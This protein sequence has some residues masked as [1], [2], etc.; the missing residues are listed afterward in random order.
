MSPPV[1]R[2]GPSQ[3]VAP[4]PDGEADVED[5]ATLVPE[6]ASHRAGEG[7]PLLLLHGMSMSWRAWSPVLPFLVG[8]HDVF[9]PTLAGHRGGPSLSADCRPGM[10]GIVDLLCAQMDEA[11]IETA[12]VAGNSLGGWVALELA[13]R[14]R[15]RSVIGFSPAGAWQARRDLVRLVGLFRVGR[16]LLEVPG[17]G[18]LM[19][20]PVLQRAG[21]RRTMC[22]PERIPSEDLSEM[23][24]DMLECEMLTVLFA[25]ETPVNPLE[26]FD[27]ALCPV[28]IAWSGRD[29]VIPYHRYGRPLRA[30][31]PG[32][33]F[34]VLPGVGHVPMWDDPRLVARTILETT[35]AVD[36]A[37]GVE[38][39]KAPRRPRRVARSSSAA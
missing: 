38:P 18:P 26:L 27:V 21:L 2:R 6:P 12:H 8:R 39:V 19:R 7:T 23:L 28:H 24:A 29:K 30:L 4:V 16:G 25:G 36:S 13:R 32:A 15:A 22:H 33:E 34:E 37:N 14:G 11:G 31:V 35:S 17:L 10:D 20:S 9:V 1:S 3:T 5:L